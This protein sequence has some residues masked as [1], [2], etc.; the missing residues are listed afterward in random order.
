M[1]QIRW[2]AMLSLGFAA[3][4]GMVAWIGDGGGLFAL[5]RRPAERP[6]AGA[7]R[8][9]Y[10]RHWTDAL[11][12]TLTLEAPPSTI[13]SQALVTDH[14]LF[15]V[16]PE[17]QIAA[18][19]AY[20]ALPGYS[21]ITTRVREL[22]LPLVRDPESVVALDPSLLIASH[23][24]SP[25]FLQ[26]V[27]ARALPVYA[28]RTVFS[29]L[30]EVSAALTLVG[31]LSGQGERAR[32]AVEAFNASVREAMQKA[33]PGAPPQRVLGYSY[34]GDCYGKGSLFEDIVTALGAVNVGTERGLGAWHRIGPEQVAAWNPD[35]IVTGSGGQPLDTVRAEL[36]A[37]PAVKMTT[38]GRRGQ[39]LVVEDRQFLAMSQH[40]L[41]LMHAI[42]DALFAGRG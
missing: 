8:G 37:D 23:I 40:V 17:S 5:D 4:A 18:V 34:Y 10:P 7:E 25:E 15:G 16:V 29:G 2:L 3:A 20:A 33:I 39:L 9:V 26:V 14:L 32:S 11:G 22:E 38:A 36:A 35:W 6:H 42:A 41:G 28:M 30:G 12:Y 1:K 31:D 24:S 27:R 19:S 13:A 21:N